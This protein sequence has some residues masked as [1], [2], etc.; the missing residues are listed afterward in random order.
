MYFCRR[1][2]FFQAAEMLQSARS[3]LKEKSQFL[4]GELAAGVTAYYRFQTFT[5]L[6]I[7]Y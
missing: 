1:T 6:S 3:S 2:S 7:G 5:N 4:G